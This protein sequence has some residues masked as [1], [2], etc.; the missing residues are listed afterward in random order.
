MLD[1]DDLWSTVYPIYMY[2]SDA[3]TWRDISVKNGKYGIYAR[4]CDDCLF[5]NVHVYE[6]RL[7]IYL[8]ECD[9]VSL[10]RC[11]LHDTP[12][13]HELWLQYCRP[14]WIEHC[15]LWEGETSLIHAEYSD[16]SVSNTIMSAVY[17]DQICLQLANSTYSGDYNDFHIAVDADTASSGDYIYQ[18]LDEW[19]D[20]TSQDWNSLTH[21]PLL[22][23]DGH[24]K[25]IMGVWSNG[26]WETSLVHSPCIDMGNPTDTYVEEP[27]PNGQRLNMGAFGNT[28]IASKSRTNAW[29][30]V[31]SQNQGGT[32]ASEVIFEWAF[33]NVEPDDIVSLQVSTNG[34]AGWVTIEA[35]IAVTNGAWAW[36]PSL[37][38]NTTQALWRVIDIGNTNIMDQCDEMFALH[39][40]PM[41]YYVNDDSVDGDVYCI[42]VGTNSNSGLSPAAPKADLHSVFETYVIGPGDTLWVDTGSYTNTS[43]LVIGRDSSGANGASVII[44][45]STNSAAGGS[46]LAGADYNQGVIDLQDVQWITLRDLIFA[47]RHG[48]SYESH[49]VRLIR[50]ENCEL[51]NLIL[52]TNWESE[53]YLDSAR[54][55]RIGDVSIDYS[56]SGEG[57]VMSNCVSCAVSN[58]LI[59]GTD[60]PGILIYG[61]EHIDVSYAQLS[62]V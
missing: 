57:I 60:G 20:W 13:W 24:L 26:V 7:G 23:E 47:G 62:F 18:R 41:N 40:Q 22:M 27:T 14:A 54:S 53:I 48:G 21:D 12:A 10:V 58:T 31:L 4:Y 6:N 9:R 16:V 50:T 32:V 34:G 56:V 39:V 8:Y 15:T 25:S 51:S 35:G 29:V 61:S 33:G 17:S 46:M 44:Q 3:I 37:F 28:D 49:G 30:L 45:G 43:S 1:R 5:E 52:Y 11:R 55:C 59:V 42:A 36:D 2:S 38:G 19:Q